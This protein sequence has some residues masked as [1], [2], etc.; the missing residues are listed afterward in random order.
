[1]SPRRDS[2]G[3]AASPAAAASGFSA[4]SASSAARWAPALVLGAAVLWGLLGIFGKQAQAEG[5]S[6]LEVGFW[7]A[8]IGTVLF[9]AHAAL[10]RARLPRGRDLAVTAAFGLVGVSVF[11]GSYQFA[12]RDGG[13]SLAAVLLYTAPA[14]V[15][16]LSWL[17]LRERLGAREMAGVAMSFGGI[18]LISLGGGEGVHATPLSVLA[19]VTSGVT[20]ALYY[21]YGRRYFARYAPAALFAVMMPVGALGL[22]PMAQVQLHHSRLGWLN[23]IGVGLLCTYAAYSLNS[24]GLRHLPATRASVISSIEP[25]VAAVLA[26]VLFAERLSPAALVGAAAVVGAALLLSTAPAPQVSR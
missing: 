2:Q 16:L 18:V 12:V 24:A 13:A 4:A 25:V 17:V 19:G 23:L 8:A 26:A 20:Y 6:P 9:G 11:Y 10:T 5:A 21:L 22:L 14:F 1:M 7:R 3:A 15:A